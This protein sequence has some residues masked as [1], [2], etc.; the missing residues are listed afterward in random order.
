MSRI[1]SVFLLSA[2][3]GV[4]LCCTLA[5]AASAPVVIAL[6]ASLPADALQA[7]DAAIT[8]IAN[9]VPSDAELSLIV[10]D[11]VVQQVVPLQRVGAAQF[12]EIQ[13]TLSSVKSTA[14]SNLAA[15]FERGLDE[16]KEQPRAQL[17][18][19]ARAIVQATDADRQTRY[20]QWIKELLLPDAAER[21]IA[22][23]LVAPEAGADA[24]LLADILGQPA[25]N[26]LVLDSDGG[27]A[28]RVMN[29]LAANDSTTV[30]TAP[31]S[32][33]NN[34]EQTPSAITS[35]ESTELAEL[36][37]LTEESV[38]VDA[39][40]QLAANSSN[41][42]GTA[43]SAE[44]SATTNAQTSVNAPPRAESKLRYV[45]YATITLLA[46]LVL[47]LLVSLFRN[48]SA[49]K[50]IARDDNTRPSAY[51]PLQATQRRTYGGAA[52]ATAAD[53]SGAVAS[54]AVAPA[55]DAPAA[56]VPRTVVMTNDTDVGG[57]TD[58]FADFDPA[59]AN[60]VLA[61]D[62]NEPDKFDNFDEI[63]ELDELADITKQRRPLDR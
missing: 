20:R 39:G 63:D 25:N 62:T 61:E 23:T 49:G 10:F 31:Q 40:N 32:T 46:L 22:I 38:A 55:V 8:A 4:L 50:K 2:T 29:I 45:W 30:A 11:D 47:G 3:L 28:S 43:T 44:A 21:G 53:A 16:L 42:T 52:S 56:T 6:D 57:V 41:A 18:V 48:R 5:R 1:R 33:T 59:E 58:Q 9:Q 15:G 60:T 24:S 14:S 35:T 7:A 36:T 34:A 51:L 54:S 26:S 19:F 13:S 12:A 37:E 17:V 27:L